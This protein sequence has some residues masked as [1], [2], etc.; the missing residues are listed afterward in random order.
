LIERERERERERAGLQ[1]KKSE[2]VLFINGEGDSE[3]F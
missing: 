2:N 3:R 1:S